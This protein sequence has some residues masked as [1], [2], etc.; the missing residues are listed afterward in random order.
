MWT[1]LNTDT[2]YTYLTILLLNTSILTT[3]IVV[4]YLLFCRTLL[5]IC[6]NNNIRNTETKLCQKLKKKWHMSIVITGSYS[7]S[8]KATKTAK[9]AHK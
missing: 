8:K 4:R 5:V 2:N 1:H 3:A 7:E 6:K 9:N